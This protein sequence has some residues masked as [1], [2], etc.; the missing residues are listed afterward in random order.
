MAKLLR[1]TADEGGKATDPAVIGELIGEAATA[2]RPK[3]RYVAGYG[4][5]PL[6]LAR[7]FLPTA[8]ST[9]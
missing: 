4:A 6:L 1:S 9:E 7:R 3:T 5:R 2:R 8:A